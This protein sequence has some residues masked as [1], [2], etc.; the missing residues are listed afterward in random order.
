[1]SYRT[2]RYKQGLS[3]QKPGFIVIDK[4]GHQAQEEGYQAHIRSKDLAERLHEDVESEPWSEGTLFDPTLPFGFRVIL[5][6][7]SLVVAL[8]ALGLDYAL[9]AYC[10]RYVGG[11]GS[12]LFWFAFVVFPGGLLLWVGLGFAYCFVD[13]LT[14]KK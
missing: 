12:G 11:F 5:C 2:Q 3:G 8:G 9:A 13:F 7:F 10:A 4:E 6:S 1:M 14:R